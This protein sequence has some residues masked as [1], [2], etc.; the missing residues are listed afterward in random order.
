MIET[1]RANG[2]P[3]IYVDGSLRSVSGLETGSVSTGSLSNILSLLTESVQQ[4]HISWESLHQRG[5]F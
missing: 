5:S 4:L 1:N 2:F 3:N